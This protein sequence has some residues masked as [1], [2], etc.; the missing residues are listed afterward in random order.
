MSNPKV[1]VG[2]PVYNG[3]RFIRLVLDSLARQDFEGFELIISDNASTDATE[4]ICRSYAGHDKR[5]RYYRNESNIGAGPNYEKVFEL[6]RGKFFKWCSHDDVILPNCIS[7]CLAV[8][9]PAPESVV[10]VYPRCELIDEAGT[11][12]G[13]MDSNVE[14]KAKQPHK[15]LA[16]VIRT[17]SYASPILGLLR[18]ETLHKTN[19]T[20]SVY[21][22]DD[23]LLAELS[24]Y[25][26][27][28]EIPEVLL[29][30]RSHPGNALAKASVNLNLD[31]CHI[32]QKATMETRKAL[33][34]WNNPRNSGQRILLPNWAERWLEYEKRVHH[35]PLA[36]QEK[37]LCYGVVPVFFSWRR[38]KTFAGYWR[39]RLL[40]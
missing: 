17:M 32:P 28:W 1:S 29:Q 11:I 24:L 26:E 4:E 10:L 31:A 22:W 30:W 25:G 39:R 9:D 8:I 18:A 15:R 3:E 7:R 6:S 38:F 34:E 37:L 13:P 40:K 20:S 21:Y 35:T 23:V 27:F 36:L 16:H 5:I 12:L 2:L 33:I 14:T 19:L